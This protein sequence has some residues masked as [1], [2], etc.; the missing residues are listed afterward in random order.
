MPGGVRCVTATSQ[1]RAEFGLRCSFF[2]CGVFRSSR[3]LLI[4]AARSFTNHRCSSSRIRPRECPRSRRQ[5]KRKGDSVRRITSV[6]FAATVFVIALQP[7]ACA[8]AQSTAAAAPKI[9]PVRADT[10]LLRKTLDSIADAHHGIV[11]YS[12]FDME[13]GAR[14]N[15][16]GDE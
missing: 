12:V 13:N 11:G 16:R 1:F 9:A 3:A 10:A 2:P 14:L 6:T 7:L 8:T 4:S 5:R 15:R